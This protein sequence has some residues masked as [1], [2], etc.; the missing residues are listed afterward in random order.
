MLKLEKVLFCFIQRLNKLAWIVKT[1]LIGY[2]CFASPGWNKSR[3]KL[4]AYKPLEFQVVSFPL[5]ILN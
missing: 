4:K 5:V 3:F 1:L 2:G